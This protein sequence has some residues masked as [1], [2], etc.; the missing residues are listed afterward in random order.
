MRRLLSLVLTLLLATALAHTEVTGVTRGGSAAAPTVT[1]TFSEP[2]ELRFSTFRVMAVPA[3]QSAGGAAAAALKEAAGSARLVNLPLP[4]LTT[5]A[6]ARLPLRP[7]LKRG[8]YVVAW[9]LLSEDGHP[10][11]GYRTFRVP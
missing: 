3:G 11:T 7:G 10:V 2:V 9:R 8:A 4:R 1:V 5:A 6:L